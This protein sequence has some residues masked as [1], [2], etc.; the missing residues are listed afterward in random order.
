MRYFPYYRCFRL[1][2]R[3]V[4]AS[5]HGGRMYN[6]SEAQKHAAQWKRRHRIKYQ[7]ENA[8]AITVSA[9]PP[10]AHSTTTTM[11]FS[12]ILPTTLRI[13]L[14]AYLTPATSA[15]SARFT[16]RHAH[17]LAANSSRAV[18]S[19]VEPSSHFAAAH[20]FEIA[21]TA[22]R[23]P[24]ARSQ[25]DFFAARSLGRAQHK[26]DWDD[27]EV[28]GPDVRQRETLLMLA[29]MTN[30]A[31]YDDRTTKGWYELG[32]EWNTV[33]CLIHTPV[34]PPD[35][36]PQSYPFGWEPDA[37]GFRGHVFAN[38]DNS[39]VIVALKGT[40]TRFMGGPTVPKDKLNDNLLFSCCCA[41]VG[42]TWSTVCGCYEGSYK[43]DQNCLENSLM[44]DS[45]FY[46]VGI[47]S[48]VFCHSRCLLTQS[49]TYTTISHTCI[50]MPTFG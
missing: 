41:R 12:S 35:S 20:E 45:L 8:S 7:L 44:E 40:N 3:L 28:T 29:N 26:L 46:S 33:R 22:M 47:V 23:I 16:L 30:N 25:N 24:R 34:H 49:R 38:E 27:T 1:V 6:D 2:P 9:P 43:C 50:P 32:P 13:L 17:G 39:T 19:D 4:R 48:N 21:T 31:Y 11:L 36:I 14:T 10:Q 5:Q 18:F 15:Q 42:P 37:D